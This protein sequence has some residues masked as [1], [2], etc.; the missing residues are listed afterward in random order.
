MFKS[1]CNYFNHLKNKKIDNY[2]VNLFIIFRMYEYYGMPSIQNN[3]NSLNFIRIVYTVFYGSN[4]DPLFS[5]LHN[6]VFEP[7]FAAG[8]TRSPSNEFA[9]ITFEMEWRAN[10]IL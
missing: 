2:N 3:I 10:E 8:S 1:T 7:L 5:C 6:D 4:I 9:D